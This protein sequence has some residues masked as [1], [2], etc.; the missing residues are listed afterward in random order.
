MTPSE[1]IGHIR[2]IS[3]ELSKEEW[4]LVDLTLKQFKLPWTDDW[5]GGDKAAYIIDMIS[6]ASDKA[7]LDLAKHLGR[8]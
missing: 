8:E 1:R 7:P 5:G 2:A 3:H 4:P 6:E